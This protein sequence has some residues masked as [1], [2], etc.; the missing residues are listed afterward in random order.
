[1]SGQQ[2]MNQQPYYDNIVN[3]NGIPSRINSIG[4][5]LGVNP[6][7]YVNRPQ[8]NSFSNIPQNMV[9]QVPQSIQSPMHAPSN[10]MMYQGVNPIAQPGM[11]VMQPSGIPNQMMQPNMPTQMNYPQM[12]QPNAG[13]ID[14]DAL[15]RYMAAYNPTP[16]QTGGSVN[17]PFFFQ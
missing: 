14:N 11:S 10:Q 3:V 15:A 8:T 4:N 5:T 12:M 17:N 6:N 2:Q 7:E 1:M 9:N 13:Q 16:N